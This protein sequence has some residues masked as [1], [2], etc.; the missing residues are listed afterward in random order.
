VE[1]ERAASAARALRLEALTAENLEF[2]RQFDEQKRL[3][4]D[5]ER[6]LRD[7]ELERGNLAAEILALQHEVGLATVAGQRAEAQ[8]R[9][10]ALRARQAE[11]DLWAEAEAASRAQ[12]HRAKAEMLTA[13]NDAL[14]AQLAARQKEVD[15]L[16][17][18]ELTARAALR[19]AEVQLASLR[20]VQDK[21]LALLEGEV[22]AS[23]ARMMAAV[24][25]NAATVL[26][27]ALRQADRIRQDAEAGAS[28][29]R[30]EALLWRTLCLR[31]PVDSSQRRGAWAGR[32]R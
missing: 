25:A 1:Q 32:H 23:E 11:L 7:A 30:D 17:E 9:A 3:Q 8:A 26:N 21:R 14:R 20:E 15:R 16:T 2:R 5:F 12:G 29:T 18:L 28:R 22:R 24:Q 19:A 13:Q 31:A 6:R 4:S 10:E 27:E